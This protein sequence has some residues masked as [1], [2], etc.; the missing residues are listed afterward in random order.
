M[1]KI[2]KS[3]IYI[4]VLAFFV[5]ACDEN[6]TTYDPLS[7]PEDAFVAFESTSAGSTAINSIES[8]ANDVIIKIVLAT[9]NQS[10]NVTV[11]FNI[12]STDAI[13]GTHYEIVDNKTQFSIAP[14]EY[15]DELRI[16]M[17]D[18]TETDGN[19]EL[20]VTL[21]G[22]SEG[23]TTGYPGPD[24]GNTVFKIT[25]LDDDCPLELAG[26]YNEISEVSNQ[27]VG[28]TTISKIEEGE[29]PGEY[30]IYGIY[31][32]LFETYWGE[33]FQEGFGNEG[34]VLMIDNGDGTVTIPNQYMGETL[35]GPWDYWMVGSGEYSSCDQSLIL[36]FN[37]NYDDT[38][39]DN[40][41][42]TVLTLELK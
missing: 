31:A 24:A 12:T 41:F 16:R 35:P 18:N 17:I 26:E 4:T 3:L 11:D 28:L 21:T 22:N 6:D 1:K 42:P 13:L 34:V 27:T 37:L 2:F 25:I 20:T 23:I 15:S 40:S 14:G 19:K 7:F 9:V 38:V 39:S 10:A 29:N 32:D 5:S 30:W 33:V 8:N 36:N